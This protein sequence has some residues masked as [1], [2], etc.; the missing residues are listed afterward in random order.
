MEYGSIITSVADIWKNAS[1]ESERYS[2]IIY[3]ESVKI[4]GNEGNFIHIESKD[5]VKGYIKKG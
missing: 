2:Q 4:L 3:G 1:T 5:G